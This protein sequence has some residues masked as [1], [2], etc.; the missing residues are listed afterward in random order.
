MNILLTINRSFYRQAMVLLQS[1][2]AHNH[3][4]IDVYIA[5]SDLQEKEIQALTDFCSRQN[6][7]LHLIQQIDAAFHGLRIAGPFPYE[8]YYRILAH[9]Y[10]PE[11]EERVLYLDSDIVCNGNLEEFY[12]MDFEGCYLIACAQDDTFLHEPDA[13]QKNWDEVKAARGEYFNTGVLLLNCRRF[14]EEKITL[15]TYRN[16]LKRMIPNYVFDQGLLNVLFARETKLISAQT[17]NYR[18]G[19]A[20]LQTTDKTTITPNYQAKLIHF[21]SEITPYKPWDL[22][23]DDEEV[24]H[25]HMNYV[26]QPPC[27]NFI[28]NRDINDLS[29]IW[30]HYAEKTPVYDELRYE[31]NVKKEWFKRGL[32]GYL[33][34][35]QVS[36]SKEA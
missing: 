34:R 29:K 28:V 21:A 13:V 11:T 22:L 7:V 36:V 27:P 26:Q 32:S 24:Q 18:Y 30:W 15:D 2:L 6:I 3:V 19:K 10:L 25:Y 4:P 17:Y 23:L 20:F 35:L 1:I 16:T 33:K 9:E 5:Y 14:R 31:M 8:V 12:H